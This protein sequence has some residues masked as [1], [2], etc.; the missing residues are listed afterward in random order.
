VAPVP[1]GKVATYKAGLKDAVDIVTCTDQWGNVATA[2]ITVKFSI[3]QSNVTVAPDGSLTFTTNEGGSATWSLPG[4]NSGGTIVSS[5]GAYKAGPTGNVSD[6]ASATDS[7]GNTATTVV[8]V[9]GGLS[10]APS[11]AEV[12]PKG[13]IA[14]SATGG[15]GSGYTWTL[16][17]NASG[18][19]VVAGSGV[20]TAGSTSGT[21][22]IQAKDSL[23]NKASVTITVACGA[24]S[25][26]QILYPYNGT[27]LPLALPAPLVQWSDNGSAS[28]A[29]VT[30]QYP[31]VGTPTFTW[32]EVVAENGALAAPYS[33][34]PGTHPVSGGGRAQIPASV[35]TAF[36]SAA[37]G[38]NAT[39]SVKTLENGSGTRPVTITLHFANAELKGTIYYQSY[40]T[41][42]VSNYTGAYGTGGPFGAATLAI[43]VGQAA[44]T[45]AAGSSSSDLS[46]C[47][48]CHSVAANGSLL[49]TQEGTNYATSDVVTL[50]S[51]SVDT[52]IP[53]TT[54][55]GRYEWPAISPDGTVLFS[56]SGSSPSALLG[57]NGAQPSG[58]YALPSGAA[59]ATTGIPANL[60]AMT[61]AF[62]TDTSAVA[63][64]YNSYDGVSLAMMNVAFSAGTWNFSAPSVLFTPAAGGAAAWPS[65]LPA[66]QNGVVFQNQ[67]QS[68]C[69]DPN[70]T[71]SSSDSSTNL[72]NIGAQGELWWVNT[73]GSPVPARLDRA[74]GTGS[75]PA[76]INGHGLATATPTTLN[77]GIPTTAEVT[78]AGGDACQIAL[79]QSLGNGN[80]ALV[81]FEPTVNPQTTGG[82][83]WVVFTSRRMYGNVAT[84]NP[85]ASDPRYSDISTQP[86]PK[87]LWVSAISNKPAG[88]MDPSFPAF[89]L[90]GQELLAGNSR[91]YWVLPACSPP[92]TTLTSANQ[93]TSQQDCC[94]TT[95]STCTLDIPITASPPLQHCVPNSSVTCSKDGAACNTDG[96]CCNLATTGSRCASGICQVANITVYTPQSV[97]Y[98]FQAVCPSQTQPV[99]EFLESD[100]S[101]PSAS[102]IAFSVQSA[103]TETALATAQSA[104]LDT[105]TTTVVAPQ[106]STSSITVDQ[107]LRALTPEV[108]SQ[109]WLRVTVTLNPS[110][111]QL[112]TPVLTSL[113][114]TFDCLANE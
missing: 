104:T 16:T 30:L 61:P 98:D 8:E 74:N 24:D 13:T 20:Y 36:E 56:N 99:W 59:L 70:G 79:G 113:Q 58:M 15:S 43:Q 107:S 25:A 88:G 83:S 67:V 29:E 96:D 50:G 10:I 28:Y 60:L 49:V 46:G 102:S 110:S 76:G 112:S 41:H 42:L 39:L 19:S 75:V 45:V 32:S 27:V 6:T 17:T 62:A 11:T 12:A 69:R 100:Q 54:N 111:D 97:E 5:T 4:N 68:D 94:Q 87:K 82:Y 53:G 34:L 93:C 26:L 84:I 23:G 105:V 77:G 1:P 7:N 95:L 48:V 80:D 72:H 108:V 89:Y 91:G 14:F 2:T 71:R 86:T 52:V 22:V 101:T 109:L 66:G 55:D 35:W 106:Y 57:S 114:P 51:P 103:G 3:T 92:S 44:P 40:G 21:D 64:N 73:S 85:W 18:G 81:N 63:F 33:A 38:N 90:D 31:A 65:F 37:A 47:R 78:A 9:G